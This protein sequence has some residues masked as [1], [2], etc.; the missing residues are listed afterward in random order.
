MMKILE[1]V[2]RQVNV[3]NQIPHAIFTALEMIDLYQ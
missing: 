1:V 2:S 3:P